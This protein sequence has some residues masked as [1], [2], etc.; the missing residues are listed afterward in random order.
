MGELKFNVGAAQTEEV[1][2]K[3]FDLIIVGA[4]PAG[5]TASIYAARYNMNV[6]IVAETFGG[7]AADAS[8]VE[9]YPGYE[10]IPGFDLMEKFKAHA[11][12]LGAKIKQGSVIEVRKNKELFELSLADGTSLTARA[13]IFALGTRRR[14]LNVPGED[15]FAG[16]G[17]SYCATCDAAFY[18]NKIVGI[19]GGSDSAAQS[20]LLL[21]EHASKVYIIYRRDKLRA[22]PA[23]VEQINNNPKI[24]VLYNVN[25][26]SL[27]GNDKLEK[28][29]LD[30]GSELKLD[31][32]FIEI[33]GIPSTEL[34]KSAGVEV[35]DRG[36]IVVN[37]DMSTNVRGIYAA[38]DVTTGSN[39]MEQII[40]ACAEGAIAAES[41][42]KF[43]RDIKSSGVIKQYH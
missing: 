4:G 31:G 16:K 37:A 30:N 27:E 12:K 33:G 20:A 17:V 25:I 9:N 11:I 2:E 24:E 5:Y 6:L 1:K 38:G 19:V 22:E 14:H 42:Y 41:A 39:G 35:N 3:D 8:F 13:V 18:K 15:K 36:F 23:Y 29:V 32:L 43:V 34:A 40:T 21:A 28:A 26:K 10:G 7:L